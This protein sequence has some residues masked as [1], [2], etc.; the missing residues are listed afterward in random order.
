MQDA[1]GDRI[2]GQYENRTRFLLPRRTYTIIR[3]DGKAFHTF[4]KGY[5]KP[6]DR[7]LMSIMD[8]TAIAMCEGIQ[9]AKLAY[10]QSD[11]ISILLT[12]FET[13]TT[14]AWFDGNLQKMASV[15]A[16]LA[17]MAFNREF[18][19]NSLSTG[20]DREKMTDVHA[21]LADC[22][23]MAMFDARVFTI[24]DAV[25]VEN[26]FIWRQ[27]DASRNS[28]QMAARAVYSHKQLEGKGTSQLH[29]L[30]HAKGINWN[31]YTTGEK[32]GRIIKKQQ[33]EMECDP[34]PSRSVRHRTCGKVTRS[35]WVSFDGNSLESEIP[36][37]TQN[38]I[39]L[40][41]LIPTVEG[42]L[43]RNYNEGASVYDSG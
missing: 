33:Y 1:L 21:I 6:F 14:C 41:Q 2:K 23:K 37:F 19:K 36:V 35:K 39:F 32:R 34:T 31:D 10:V 28:V 12:D 27:N 16:S 7:D 26:Y 15:A 4:T 8:K 24:P 9:G 20:S 11:E 17:T 43:P 22:F 42:F 40:R 29:D 3:V 5:D 13:D 30:L 38:R 25:E 18:L